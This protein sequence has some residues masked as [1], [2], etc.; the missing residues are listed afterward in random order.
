MKVQIE[1]TGHIASINAPQGRLGLVSMDIDLSDV[2]LQEP[3]LYRWNGAQF[4]LDADIQAEIEQSE[5][6]ASARLYL[7]ETDFY[8]TRKLETGSPVPQAIGAK[9]AK[10]RALLASNLPE[11]EE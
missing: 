3:H 1:E 9:R 10:A 8:I 6:L 2:V 5:K 7:N 4:V 11:F